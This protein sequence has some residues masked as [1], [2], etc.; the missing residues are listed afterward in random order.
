MQKELIYLRLLFYHS[1]NSTGNKHGSVMNGTRVYWLGHA[2]DV[3]LTIKYLHVYK[4]SL[5]QNSQ[6]HSTLK[7]TRLKRIILNV[8]SEI[9]S[10]KVSSK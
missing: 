8:W 2:C 9:L 4:Q 1:Y 3:M 6:N 7:L 5:Q 10:F